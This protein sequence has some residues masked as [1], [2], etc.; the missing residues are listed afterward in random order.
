[1]LP[2]FAPT[3]LNSVLPTTYAAIRN[4]IHSEAMTSR[5]ERS[6]TMAGFEKFAAILDLSD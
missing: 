2:T 3:P 5:R 1:M 6:P 4:P